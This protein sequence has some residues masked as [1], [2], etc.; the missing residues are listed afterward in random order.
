MERVNT[1]A[2]SPICNR[3]QSGRFEKAQRKQPRIKSSWYKNPRLADVTIIC[4]NNGERRFE[5]PR[6]I[7]CN[8]ID[9]FQCSSRNFREA[10]SREIVLTGDDADAVESMLESAYT[11]IIPKPPME[12]Q[13]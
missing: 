6:L 12:H 2:S 11:T 9:W 1:H 10:S 5:A 4:G 13:C 8:A 3:T 7:L